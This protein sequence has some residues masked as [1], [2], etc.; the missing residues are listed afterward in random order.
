MAE[1]ENIC[2]C[3]NEKIHVIFKSGIEKTLLLKCDEGTSD[4]V[5]KKYFQG[6]EN[7]FIGMSDLTEKRNVFFRLGELVCYEIYIAD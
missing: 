4:E 1:K 6:T 3:I 5:S 2:K 7:T